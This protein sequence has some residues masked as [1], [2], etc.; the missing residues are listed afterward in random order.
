MY[1]IAGRYK[2][3]RI[4][5]PDQDIRPVMSR[6]RE[7]IFSMLYS[8]YGGL[9][10]LHFLDLF[11]GSAIMS[12]EAASRG[13]AYIEAVERD[14]RKKKILEDNLS[15]LEVPWKLH[16]TTVQEYLGQTFTDSKLFDI[17][18]FDPPFKMKHKTRLLEYLNPKL[19]HP[20]GVIL[21]HLPKQEEALLPQK[22]ELDQNPLLLEYCKRYGGSSVCFYQKSSID[23]Y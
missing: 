1:I 21:M 6:M 14:R 3:Q 8:R 18:Y 16:I 11:C 23:D 17:I 13:A 4:R 20:A 2:G 19:L 15:I 9:E 22:L 12:L 7:S 5:C 10:G